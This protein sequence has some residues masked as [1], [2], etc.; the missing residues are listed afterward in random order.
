MLCARAPRTASKCASAISAL[1]FF[2]P[3]SRRHN[4]LGPPNPVNIYVRVYIR[5]ASRRH[6]DQTSLSCTK[7]TLTLLTEAFLNRVAGGGGGVPGYVKLRVSLF[8]I[9]S[10]YPPP[11]TL[12]SIPCSHR[13]A[14]LYPTTPCLLSS[15]VHVASGQTCSACMLA[16]IIRLRQRCRGA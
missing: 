15:S 8:S 12:P 6:S 4:L 13:K 7:V 3:P 2:S 5:G 14:S 16:Y 1:L 11:S 10:S 9:R